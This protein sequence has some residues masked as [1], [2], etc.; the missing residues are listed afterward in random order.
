MTFIIAFV[1]SAL[2]TSRTLG[3]FLYPLPGKLIF[4]LDI[5]PKALVEVVL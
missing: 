3:N 5:G 4:N 1:P 2:F